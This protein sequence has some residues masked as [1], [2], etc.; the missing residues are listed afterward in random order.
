MGNTQLLGGGQGVGCDLAGAV[1]ARLQFRDAPGVDVEADHGAM[2]T[3][4]DRERQADV[5]QADDGERGVR[6]SQVSEVFG[7]NGKLC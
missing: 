3:E 1:V 5:A 2:L 6:G 4:F 7:H